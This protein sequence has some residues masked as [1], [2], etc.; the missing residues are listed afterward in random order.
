M[1]IIRPALALIG[2]VCIALFYI[3]HNADFLGLGLIFF[4]MG[5]VFMGV[6]KRPKQTEVS[7]KPTGK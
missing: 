5:L 1:N 2:L 7:K 4:A 3:Y 6:F